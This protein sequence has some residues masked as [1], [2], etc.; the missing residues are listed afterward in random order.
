MKEFILLAIERTDGWALL[1]IWVSFLS[2]RVFELHSKGK[3]LNKSL[4]IIDDSIRE[5]LNNILVKLDDLTN[6]LR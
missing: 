1:A 4:E 3:A 2:Y 5:L 6:Y